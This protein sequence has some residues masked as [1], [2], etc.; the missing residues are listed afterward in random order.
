MR[1]TMSS[2]SCAPHSSL[3]F[4][5]L[6]QHLGEEGF[7]HGGHTS[8][9]GVQGKLVQILVKSPNFPQTRNDSDHRGR[10]AGRNE[11]ASETLCSLLSTHG[12][13]QTADRTQ[14][15]VCMGVLTN[16]DV[17][18]DG[19][20]LSSAGLVLP[21]ECDHIPSVDDLVVVFLEV[22]EDGPSSSVQGDI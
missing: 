9:Q 7:Q 3:A 1:S 20:C 19:S 8:L 22:A 2:Q 21:S 14:P 11:R 6:L 18:A 5:G 10:Q 17:E 15:A 4:D 16:K 13:R 12:A